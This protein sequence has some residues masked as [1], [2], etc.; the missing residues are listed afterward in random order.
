MFSSPQYPKRPKHEETLF[1]QGR[2][3][4][5]EATGF[6]SG[7]RARLADVADLS[8]EKLQGRRQ[9]SADYWQSQ[10]SGG[11]DSTRPGLSSFA[12]AVMAGKARTRIG[13]MGDA[14]VESNALRAR[15]GYSKFG[16]GLRSG[17]IRDM[18]Q[19]SAGYDQV[20]AA[21]MQAAQMR[22]NA[23]AGLAGMAVG[24]AAGWGINKWQAGRQSLVNQMTAFGNQSV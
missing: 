9:E 5:H 2:A 8:D 24:G 20:N 4:E 16:Q 11:Y 19:L 23:Y 3:M 14:A 22:D 1:N 13:A 6:Q 21:K 18:A 10:Q 7:M 15:A 17:S 12:R